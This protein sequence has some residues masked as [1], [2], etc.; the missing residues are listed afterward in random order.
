MSTDTVISIIQ[1]I[2]IIIAAGLAV[3][4]LREAAR[5]R[6]LDGFPALA[7]DLENDADARLSIYTDLP[8]LLAKEKDEDKREFI[9][10]FSDEQKSN[11]EKVCVTFDRMG[12]LVIHGLLPKDVAFSM[13][14]DV[15]LR[16]WRL[17]EP[18]VQ[19]KRQHRENDLWMMYFEKLNEKCW[20]YWEHELSKHPEWI[21]LK[22]PN[23]IFRYV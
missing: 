4:Q 8:E 16:I 5:A 17:V 7:A 14:F 13:Y 15:V 2:T 1:T 11:I 3:W 6:S 20:E 9:S 22:K 10:Q 18:Y 21:Y 12:V 19:Q 23:D